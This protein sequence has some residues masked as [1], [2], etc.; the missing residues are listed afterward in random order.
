M[1]GF[2]VLRFK[3]ASGSI[4]PL[5]HRLPQGFTKVHPESEALVHRKLGRG[6]SV[7]DA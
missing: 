4:G 6:L 7:C 2:E 1:S 5:T 3:M